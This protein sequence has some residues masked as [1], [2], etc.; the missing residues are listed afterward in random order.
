MNIGQP[1]NGVE[2]GQANRSG[3]GLERKGELTAEVAEPGRERPTHRSKVAVIRCPAYDQHLVN[4]AVHRA[5]DLATAPGALEPARLSPERPVLVK[6]N[7][8]APRPPEDGVDTHPAVLRAVISALRDRGA[9]EIIVGDSSGGVSIRRNVT[10]HAL[11]VSG[12]AAAAEDMGARAVA[13]DR[14]ETVAVANPRGSGYPSLPLSKLAVQAGCLV[15]VS[16]FKTHALTVLTGAVKNLFGTVPGPAKREAHRRH[17]SIEIFTHL[18]LDI[19]EALQPAL[20]VVDAVVAMEGNGPSGGPLRQV[21]LILAGTDPVAV[22]TV[23]AA[24]AGIDPLKVPTTRL[25]AA[26]GLGTADLDQIDVVG[27][28]LEEVRVPRFKLPT[29]ARLAARVPAGLTRWAVSFA[30]VRPWFVADECTRCGVCVKSCPA[31]A[32]A[33]TK[34]GPI[35]SDEA[36]VGCFCCHELCPSQAVRLRYRNPLANAILRPERH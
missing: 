13:F 14:F 32:L 4:D 17:A 16:K 5:I 15:S 7:V 22:D 2:A 29:A 19:V 31:D 8:L 27:V 23:L 10:E 1:N 3:I 35:L 30:T 33:L 11:E 28:P 26:R 20:H 18:L 24:I 34:S 6:P 12:L 25:G 9:A 21:G 36:C